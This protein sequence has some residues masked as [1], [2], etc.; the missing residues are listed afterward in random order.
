MRDGIYGKRELLGGGLLGT[1]YEHDPIDH[2]GEDLRVCDCV[3]GRRVHDDVAIETAR[4][5]EEPLHARGGQELGRIG[6]NRAAE[7]D[8]QGNRA[9][10]AKAQ[11]SDVGD[12][13][14]KAC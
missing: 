7:R 8:V 9:Y 3:D 4:R 1:R 5:L 11:G 6:R 10:G 2:R 14:A 12:V 13:I